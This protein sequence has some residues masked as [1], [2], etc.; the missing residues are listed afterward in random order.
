[1][2]FRKEITES[3][4][5]KFGEAVTE[6][7]KRGEDILSLGLG[8][9]DFLTP[10][11]LLEALKKVT[12]DGASSKYSASLGLASLRQ[13]IAVDLKE[14]NGINCTKNNI[15]I[16]PGTKQALML[17]LMA[18]LE[19]G[20]EV[21]VVVPAYV[22]YVSQVYLAEPDA[23]I[24]FVE[25]NKTDYRLDLEE[26]ERTITEH[27]KAIII[28]TPHN[29]TGCMIDERELKRLYE[30]TSNKNIYILSDEIYDKLVFGKITH[31][32]IGSLEDFTSRVITLGGFGK[33]LAITGWR[34]GYACIPES[35]M[36]KINILQQHINTNTSTI[37]QMAI[38]TAW[39]LP[40]GHLT[41]YIQ[42][43]K[44]RVQLYTEFLKN[45]PILSGSNP[46]G[47]FFVFV[48]IEK[49]KVDSV[50]FSS[51]LV[52]KTGVATTPGIAFGKQWDD[53]IR[54]SLA[55]ETELLIEAFK[56]VSI[57]IKEESWK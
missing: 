35:L 40:D 15:I 23:V 22:S 38:D 8:E 51:K 42:K 14:R 7:K 54:L 3:L 37:I 2:I 47:T 55:I 33:T 16:T 50:T 57:F 11:E 26:V 9:P 44:S 5:L 29:P 13:K 4:T 49:L 34:I 25:L 43:L 21:I 39:P 31:F 45:N 6:R 17:S 36:P 30:I 56:R 18:L 1:M 12:I 48:N 20:D 32:S 10:V 24:R 52:D 27:T 46:S 19:P 53:H 28:N 41:G